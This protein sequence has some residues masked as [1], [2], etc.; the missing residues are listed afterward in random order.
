MPALDPRDGWICNCELK[1]SRRFWRVLAPKVR[2]AIAWGN[3][4]GNLS[5]NPE[6]LKAQDKTSFTASGI[7]SAPSAL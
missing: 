1:Y 7:Y 4:L 5:A 2:N 6:A 3:A